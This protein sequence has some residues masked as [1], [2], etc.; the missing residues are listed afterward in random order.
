M[1]D[2]AA[3]EAILARIEAATGP[4]R[5]LDYDIAIMV[6]GQP[7]TDPKIRW[8]YFY[9]YTASIDAALA[10]TERVLD[11][12]WRVGNTPSGRA[13]CQLGANGIEAEAATPPLAILAATVRAMIATAER[14]TS[15]L[16][17]E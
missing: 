3:L 9:R 12:S 14:A 1:I 17:P 13:F 15:H 5:E 10:L 7:D 2:R 8:A 6:R 4:D 16:P 11:W